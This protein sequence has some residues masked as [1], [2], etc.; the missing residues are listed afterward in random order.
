MSW[1]DAQASGGLFE[2][3]CGVHLFFMY[4]ICRRRYDLC[5]GFQHQAAQAE[6]SAF[7]SLT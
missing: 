4:D 7:G 2:S 5:L 3:I 1:K 6:F